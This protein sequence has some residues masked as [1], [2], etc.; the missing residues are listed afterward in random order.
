M[1]CKNL[2]LYQKITK[3]PIRFILDIVTAVKAL[4]S[5]DLAMF[6]AIFLAHISVLVWW[7]TGKINISNNRVSL[8]KLSG[9]YKGSIVW[10][11]FVKGKKIFSRLM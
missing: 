10:Q 2:P 7:I 8:E 5:F 6:K 4:V 9:V 11:F 3:L 1:L